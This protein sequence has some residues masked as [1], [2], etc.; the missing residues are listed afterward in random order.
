MQKNGI[1]TRQSALRKISLHIVH[2]FR[3]FRRICEKENGIAS[4][5]QGKMSEMEYVSLPCK[6][7]SCP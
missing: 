6:L 1:I 2:T 7:F 5:I 3:F 4:L